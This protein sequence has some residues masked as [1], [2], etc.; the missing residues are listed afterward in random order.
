MVASFV[1]S[2]LRGSKTSHRCLAAVAI[3][4]AGAAC[5]PGGASEVSPQEI[6]DLE[7]QIADKPNDG[8]LLLRYGA[9]L[10]A[11]GRCDSATVVS[12]R[13]GDLRPADALG[14]MVIGQCLEQSGDYDQAI[15]TYAAFTE[16]HDDSRG[17]AAVRAREML[18]RRQ[19]STAQA[20]DAL[21]REQELTAQP[22]NINA[23]AVLPLTIVGDS[24]YAPLGRGLAQMLISDLS[25]LQ[26]FTLVERLQVGALLQELR[27]AETGRVDPATAAR[28]GRLV[29]AGRMVQ[30]VANIPS[31]GDVRL[32]ATVVQGDGQVTGP[33]FTTG[34]LRDLLRMEKELVVGISLRLGYRLSEAER[35]LILENGTENLTAFLSYSQGLLAEDIGDYSTAA[36]HFSNA[37]Q[38]DPGFDMARTQY[39]AA[40]AAPAVEGASANQVTTVSE[41]AV[42][43]PLGPGDPVLSA[44]TSVV[45]DIAATQAEQNTA[46]GQSGG[47][48][49]TTTN[50]SEPSPTPAAAGTKLLLTV[51]K[52]R[53]KP[54]LCPKT[55][56]PSSA[57]GTTAS[58]RAKAANASAATSRS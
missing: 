42:A 15:A 49:A 26:R 35:Q 9:A 10:F 43:E 39:E 57:P 36:L 46:S 32:E 14:P 18:A 12:R 34:R 41:T 19:R 27:L 6:P 37:V 2:R 8:K 44:V 4:F 56:K 51:P 55:T 52:G 29:R 24:T 20:R 58:S 13:G 48:A 17:T 28:V 22:A 21:A 50:A 23:I 7:T 1:R 11:A 40:A 54:A 25:L 5:I 30:G 45:V 47:Q 38:A 53:S 33:E 16:A 3:A 31:Q